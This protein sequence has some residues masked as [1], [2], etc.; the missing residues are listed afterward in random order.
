MQLSPANDSSD[1]TPTCLRV[2]L[3]EDDGGDRETGPGV[4]QNAVEGICQMSPGGQLLRVNRAMAWIC[5]YVSPDE[6]GDEL[7]DPGHD[8]HVEPL[9]RAEFERR[10]HEHGEVLA[11]ESRIRRKDGVIIWISENARA[12]RDG[13]GDLLHYESKVTDITGR[14]MAEEGLRHSAEQG[15]LEELQLDLARQVEAARQFASGLAH[16]YNNELSVI[17]GWAQL[18]VDRG[19]LPPDV[20][21]SLTHIIEAGNRAASL[22]RQ[23]LAFSRQGAEDSRAVDPNVTINEIAMLL[24]KQ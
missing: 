11:A 6:L 18:M 4:Q 5:G 17:M 9:R 19:T 23:L 13:S 16:D 2:L 22:T 24:R 7:H 10:L 12:V 21:G 1:G 15:R 14:K 20:V 3:L 8:L